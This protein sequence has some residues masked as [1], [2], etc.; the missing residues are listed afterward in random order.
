MDVI[1]SIRVAHLHGRQIF[2]SRGIPTAEVI[3][4]LSDGT[5]TAASVPSGASTGKYEACEL[6][7]NDR[8]YGGKSVYAAVNAI[9]TVL[10]DAVCGLD[11]DDQY[12]IDL[13]MREADGTEN[14]RHLGA[15]A[16]LAVSLA[17]ARAAAASRRLPLFR[18]LGGTCA[19][20]LPLPFMNVLNGGVHASNNL[21]IQE[22]MIV[23]IGASNFSEAMKMGTETYHALKT[24]LKE[25]GLSSA[26]GDEGGFA[27]SLSS[28]EEAL[29]YLTDAVEK[30]GYHPGKDISFALDVA[31]SGWYD[32][33]EYRLPK[34]GRVMT[35]D[36]LFRYY[37]K[38][39]SDYPI[40]SIEDP[41]GE[42]DWEAFRMITVSDPSLQIVGD[43]LFV[44]NPARIRRGIEM[45]AGN[46]VLIKPN[47][48]GTLSETLES[49]ALA[50][51]NRFHTMI[52]HRSGETCDDF[53]ADLA[54]AVNAGEIKTGAPCRGERLAKYNRLLRIEEL[55]GD[56]ARFGV[57]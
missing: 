15:N 4:T 24:L 35:R 38:I 5:E 33:G 45:G 29:R 9:D 37:R 42:E 50:A 51:E 2:D 27:P 12:K 11:A 21:D 22:F 10:N 44:T 7:D 3:V 13:A 32:G 28:D 19:R 39:L 56:S 57:F 25:E 53:I 43:D 31:A 18:Y 16:I 14:K 26:V 40:V 36:E 20:L 47:Q 8:G 23:P 52:S 34:R 46:A 17:I 54:V 30:A 6:R 55:L 1:S 41:F 49:I 48:I